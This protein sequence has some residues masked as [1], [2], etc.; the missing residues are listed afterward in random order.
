MKVGCSKTSPDQ[1]EWSGV[2]YMNH[3]SFSYVDGNKRA[4]FFNYFFLIF[5]ADI[6]YEHGLPVDHTVFQ[7]I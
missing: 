5:I 7:S 1:S 3:L 2:R 4:I 6:T